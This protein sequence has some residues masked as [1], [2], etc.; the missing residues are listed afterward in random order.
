MAMNINNLSSEITSGLSQTTP[1]TETDGFARGV[2]EEIIANGVATTGSPTGTISGITGAGMSTLI[3]GYAGYPSVSTELSNFCTEIA[4]H[5]NNNAI[6]TYPSSPYS[7]NGTISNLNGTTLANAVKTAV[8]YPSVS[9]ELQG[10]CDAV[11]NHV[12]NNAVCNGGSIT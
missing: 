10:M 11:V 8:G 5:I 12:M 6:V 1:T 4:N 3:E 9:S 2:I 7:N